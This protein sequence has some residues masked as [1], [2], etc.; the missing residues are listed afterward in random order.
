MTYGKDG[1]NLPP[2]AAFINDP[3]AVAAANKEGARYRIVDF[4][5]KAGLRAP[6]EAVE[7]F[8]E[9]VANATFGAPE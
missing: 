6:L 2:H 7:A 3:V 4:M 8:V 9:E 5:E 1:S